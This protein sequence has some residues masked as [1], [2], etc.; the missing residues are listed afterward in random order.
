LAQGLEKVRAVMGISLHIDSGYRCPELNQLVRGVP[1]SAHVSGYAAD[2]TCAAFGTPLEI[3]KKIAEYP[4]IL[5]DQLI[6]EGTWIHFSVAPTMRQQIL[7]A[8]FAD[9]KATYTDGLG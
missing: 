4:Q 6:Q 8:H 9:G 3:V 5:F 2:F 1:T 7:T